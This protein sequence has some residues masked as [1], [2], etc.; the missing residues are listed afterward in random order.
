MKD[1]PVQLPLNR[2]LPIGRIGT[3]AVDADVQFGLQWLPFPGK[4]KS[5]D[6]G[7]II[8]LKKL[9]VDGQ[10]LLIGTENDADLLHPPSLLLNQLLQKRFELPSLGKV[11]GGRLVEKADGFLYHSLQNS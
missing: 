1:D 9:P 11:K 4:R 6:V 5:D 3:D 2:G 8:V 10:Q 7:K